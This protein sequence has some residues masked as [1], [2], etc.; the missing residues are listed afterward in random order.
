ML[1]EECSLGVGLFQERAPELVLL[2]RVHEDQLVI[3]GG[4]AVVNDD[5]HPLPILPEL[6]VEDPTV[7]LTGREGL[8]TGHHTVQQVLVTAQAGHGSQQPAVTCTNNMR[9]K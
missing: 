7:S 8:V 9:E 3:V 5:V 4:Q 1:N 6:E 2:G